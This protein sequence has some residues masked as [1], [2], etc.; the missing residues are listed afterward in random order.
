[1]DDDRKG[2]EF[3]VQNA[4]NLLAAD[5]VVVSIVVVV[6]VADEGSE[7]VEDDVCVNQDE[8]DDV[9][10]SQN[11][12]DDVVAEVVDADL[13]VDDVEVE[14]ILEVFANDNVNDEDVNDDDGEKMSML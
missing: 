8:K 9:Y 6:D 12:K 2:E 10:V 4:V 11:T 7:S 1:M 13:L 3:D 5:E 14:G